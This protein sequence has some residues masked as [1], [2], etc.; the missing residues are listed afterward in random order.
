MLELRGRETL[1]KH[2]GKCITCTKCTKRLENTWKIQIKEK[3]TKCY[4]RHTKMQ[5][6]SARLKT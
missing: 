2:I 6:I 1:W 3:N 4:E 5:E